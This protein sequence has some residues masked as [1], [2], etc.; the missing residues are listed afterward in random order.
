M[1]IRANEGDFI[2][3]KRKGRYD[4]T[5]K[6]RASTQKN[7]WPGYD[8][9]REGPSFKVSTPSEKEEKECNLFL[10][11]PSLSSLS[12][13]LIVLSSMHQVSSGINQTKYLL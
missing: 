1:E 2:K 11:I 13:Y 6:R 7:R 3:R 5:G 4:G 12:L 10:L 9:I 8:D